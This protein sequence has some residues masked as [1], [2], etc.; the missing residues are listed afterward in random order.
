MIMAAFKPK[1]DLKVF[2]PFKDESKWIRWWN[3]FKI[4]H[5]ENLMRHLVLSDCKMRCM[6][7]YWS[8]FRHLQPN[9]YSD[10]IDTPETHDK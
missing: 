7:Y 1:I 8:R 6:G 2:T 5:Q 10:S 9:P 4:A 3:H